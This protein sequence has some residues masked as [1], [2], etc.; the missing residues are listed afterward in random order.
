MMRQLVPLAGAKV[1][2]GVKPGDLRW[3]HPAVDFVWPTATGEKVYMDPYQF[4]AMYRECATQN[5]FDFVSNVTAAKT[6]AA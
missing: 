3:L 4:L 5:Y 2:G 1:S 6:R